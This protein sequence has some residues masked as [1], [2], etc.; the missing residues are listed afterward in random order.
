M[1]KNLLLLIHIVEC[2][3]KIRA[4]TL[5]GKSSFVEPGIV[6]DAVLRNLQLLAEDTQRLSA[7]IKQSYPEIL[8]AQLS[9]FRNRLT[10]EY[11]KID[12]ELVWNVVEQH[13]E[14]LKSAVEN[15]IAQAQ[16]LPK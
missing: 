16:S 14:P 1:N 9:G 2:I 6:Q 3:D 4:Y 11:M 7:D 13:L 8:W 15:M 12:V 5:S 10:H